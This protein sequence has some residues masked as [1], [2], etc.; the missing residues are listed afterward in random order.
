VPLEGI[1]GTGREVLAISEVWTKPRVWSSYL[2]PPTSQELEI[3]GLKDAWMSRISRVE[4]DLTWLLRLPCHK[5]WSQIQ[6][7]QTIQGFLDCILQQF[8]RQY[9]PIPADKQVSD[10]NR[11]ILHKLFL[12]F[13]R[14]STYKESSQDFFSPQY[15][16]DMIYDQ[17]IL[18]MPKIIDM[19]S[20]FR[21][22][23]LDI[24]RKMV[25]NIF[26][27]Q[28][29]YFEDLFTTA[30]T[31]SK[32]FDN[33]GE[34][35]QTLSMTPPNAKNLDGFIDLVG[36][37][38]DIASSSFSLVHVYP[39]ASQ[40]LHLAGFDSRLASFYQSTIVSLQ[41]LLDKYIEAEVLT[42]ARSSH[43]SGLIQLARHRA[44][45]AFRTIVEFNCISPI[46]SDNSCD[47][48]DV[49]EHFLSLFTTILQERT[50]LVDYNTKHNLG[51]D[52][53]VFEQ[54]GLSVD[55]TRKHYILDALCESTQG[56]SF[57][58]L[59]PEKEKKSSSP[60]AGG[61]PS[62][63]VHGAGSITSAQTKD[64]IDSMISSVRDLLPYLGEG[65]V[66][67]CLE[68]YQFK[69]DEVVNAILEGN[70]APHLNDLDQALQRTKPASPEPEPLIAGRG[71]Y[72]N[73]EFDVNTRDVVD[74]S[75]IH[76]GK[77]NKGGDFKKLLDDKSDLDSKGMRER[78]SRLGIVTDLEVMVGEGEGDYDD[79]YD[80]T[81]DDVAMGQEEPDSRDEGA[82]G[83]KFVLPVALGGGK[84]A[85]PGPSVPDDDDEDEE[86]EDSG[87]KRM[88]FARNPEEMRA[89]R[90]RAR[91]EMMSRNT[92]KQHHPVKDVV[93]RAK[94]QGQDKSV[95][96][97]RARKNANKGKGQRVGADKKMSKG[98]F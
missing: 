54:A 31:L 58:I 27:V 50:F 7:D 70:L 75:R 98:M 37:I 29:K 44:V 55:P 60:P 68:H 5:F 72:D 3:S 30:E 24:T 34:Q 62:T 89:Q 87:R 80:D 67:K 57:N 77:K 63:E 12:V 92:K 81:Y 90:E 51:D 64:E 66:E 38:I 25:E 26:K 35:F 41:D 88:D 52:F 40:P 48:V 21:S 79:E 36:F 47:K 46:L 74:L 42:V 61:A 15:Y 6:F 82:G 28:P 65:F 93:G 13:L 4:E 14:L 11:G 49:L 76:R 56:S 91:Q 9:D 8:P 17:F 43:Y 22:C 97:N 45:L 33:V 86:E 84:I 94:G 83:R 96:I 59:Q 73:D 39:P 32:A 85:R 20:L 10:L 53:L 78:F 18:D 19:C 2:P 1:N 95:L 71:V 16:G 69:V 23:N